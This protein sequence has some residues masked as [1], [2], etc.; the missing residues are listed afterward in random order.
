MKIQLAPYPWLISSLG[1]ALAM[2]SSPREPVH[3]TDS[4]ALSQLLTENGW[5]CEWTRFRILGRKK[6]KGTQKHK[7]WEGKLW[8]A[9]LGDGFLWNPVWTLEFRSLPIQK[10][11]R[12][13]LRRAFRLE[14]WLWGSIAAMLT[15]AL[16]LPWCAQLEASL[17]AHGEEPYT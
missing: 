3:C 6:H 14:P 1:E 10:T 12:S 4:A 17:D 15:L 8:H 5:I 2:G 7:R 13:Q 9:G 16:I 11:S